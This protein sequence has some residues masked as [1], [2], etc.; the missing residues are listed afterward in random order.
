[1][2]L[3]NDFVNKK[4]FW[5]NTENWLIK[6]DNNQYIELKKNLLETIIHIKNINDLPLTIINDIDCLA[7]LLNTHSIKSSIFIHKLKSSPLI[8]NQDY[9]FHLL[10]TGIQ[11]DEVCRFLLFKSKNLK[12]NSKLAYFILTN[13]HEYIYFYFYRKLLK[14]ENFVLSLFH[15]KNFNNPY[16][17]ISLPY[18][19]K[20]SE[21]LLLRQGFPSFQTEKLKIHFNQE[22]M[23]NIK[24]INKILRK[25]TGHLLYNF[26]PYHIKTNKDICLTM[27][28]YHPEYNI[29]NDEIKTLENF[30]KCSRFW[31][32]YND[33]VSQIKYFGTLFNNDDNLF[34]ALECLKDFKRISRLEPPNYSFQDHCFAQFIKSSSSKMLKDFLNTEKGKYFLEISSHSNSDLNT[35]DTWIHENLLI[36]LSKIKLYNKMCELKPLK[37]TKQLKL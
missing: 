2:G 23:V 24:F 20:I 13:K 16:C 28:K 14:D 5:L 12:T 34:Q 3:L 10:K 35:I 17:L 4:K 33:F 1:M 9:L 29:L 36:V 31:L 11:D 18:H 27:L 7:C 21:L 8:K 22:L 15:N 25:P 6:L 32:Y 26:L 30:K 37:K 19:A